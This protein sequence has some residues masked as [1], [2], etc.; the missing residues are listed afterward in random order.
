MVFDG[1]TK[2]KDENGDAISVVLI[3]VKKGKGKLS[4]EETLIRKAV[5]EVRVSWRTIV[6]KDEGAGDAGNG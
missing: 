1:Y 4:R 5:E 3:E 6:M 2:A